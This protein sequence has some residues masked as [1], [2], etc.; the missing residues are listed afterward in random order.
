MPR[1]TALVGLAALLSLPAHGRAPTLAD[2][3]AFVRQPDLK[4]QA[5]FAAAAVGNA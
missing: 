3:E 1:R 5:A 4:V 2:I